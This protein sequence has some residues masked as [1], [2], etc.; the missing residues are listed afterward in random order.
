MVLSPK[1]KI[2]SK[3]VKGVTRGGNTKADEPK[4]KVVL[5]LASVF[6]I[7]RIYSGQIMLGPLKIV[8]F[9][10]FFIWY[11]I[12]LFRVTINCLNKSRKGI[13]GIRSFDDENDINT[14]YILGLIV[15]SIILLNVISYLFYLFLWFLRAMFAQK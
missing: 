14:S 4:K 6:G 5:L 2:K 1:R 3:K 9:G 12:D 15:I 8:T 11:I 10:G 13:C 7:D